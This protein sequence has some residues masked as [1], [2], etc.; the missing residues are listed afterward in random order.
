MTHPC[1]GE[2]NLRESLRDPVFA[3]MTVEGELKVLD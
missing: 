1:V 2:G 3:G